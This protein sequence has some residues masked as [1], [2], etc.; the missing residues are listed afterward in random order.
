MSHPPPEGQIVQLIA[1]MP[2]E[3]LIDSAVEIDLDGEILAGDNI[4]LI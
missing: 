4:V 1:D 3:Q 2:T